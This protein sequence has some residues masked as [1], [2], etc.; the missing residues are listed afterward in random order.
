MFFTL[1][2]M[3]ILLNSSF[4]DGPLAMT[5]ILELELVFFMLENFE[6]STTFI[7]DVIVLDKFFTSELAWSLKLMFYFKKY[8]KALFAEGKDNDSS[9]LELNS[10]FKN[11]NALI[12]T[13]PR[14]EQ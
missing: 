11:W 5:N 4:K 9:S 10:L 14:D 8:L 7:I 2:R 1:L 12:A 13:S 3:S 6:V